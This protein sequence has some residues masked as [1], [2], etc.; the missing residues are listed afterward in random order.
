M[1][2]IMIQDGN[3]VEKMF[4]KWFSQNIL[5]MF[6]CTFDKFFSQFSEKYDLVTTTIFQLGVVILL[7]HFGLL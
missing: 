6:H 2:C 1:E 7:V 3:G 4:G 5:G